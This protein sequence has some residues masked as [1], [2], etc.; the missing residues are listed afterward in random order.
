MY[1][2]ERENADKRLQSLY[3]EAVTLTMKFVLKR[4]SHVF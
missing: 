3:A 4:I 2:G 1:E